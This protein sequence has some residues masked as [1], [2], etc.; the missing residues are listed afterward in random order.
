MGICICGGGSQLQ[1]LAE[2]LSN[3]LKMR[4]WLAED[5][6]TCVVRGTGFVLDDLESSGRFLVGLSRSGR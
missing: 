2:R 1:N 4:V 6:M 5:P 3:D